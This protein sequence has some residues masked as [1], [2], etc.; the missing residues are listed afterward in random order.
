M[1]TSE[2][3]DWLISILIT[4]IIVMVINFGMW[5]ISRFRKLSET[6]MLVYD[7]LKVAQLIA[8]FVLVV[9][10]VMIGLDR[11]VVTI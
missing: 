8:A 7:G 4:L 9:L 1:N 3:Y 2:L 5:V 6:D 10:S 11:G